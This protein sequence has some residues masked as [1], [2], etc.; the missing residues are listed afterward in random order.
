MDAG[1]EGGWNSVGD[2]P[3]Y[4]EELCASAVELSFQRCDEV[5]QSRDMSPSELKREFCPH[6]ACL[7]DEGVPTVA[8]SRQ[9]ASITRR[10]F[11]KRHKYFKQNIRRNVVDSCRH[12]LFSEVA[13]G[14][15]VFLTV[16]EEPVAHPASAVFAP[17][18]RRQTVITTLDPNRR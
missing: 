2:I 5:I 6:G 17:L 10:C 13:V 11:S 18:D 3:S 14:S 12:L 8:N 9:R 16:Q 1:R 7:I 15:N 4:I